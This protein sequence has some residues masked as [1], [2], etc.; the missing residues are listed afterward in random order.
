M[1]PGI[2]HSFWMCV[3]RWARGYQELQVP[4][5]RRCVTDS[6]TRYD[7]TT[8]DRCPEMNSLTTFSCKLEEYHHTAFSRRAK[9]AERWGST[10]WKDGNT[11]LSSAGQEQRCVGGIGIVV[12]RKWFSRN[13]SCCFALRNPC[14]SP[15]RRSQQNS[16]S[17]PSYASVTANSD[18]EVKSSVMN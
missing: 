3:L 10:T 7:S 15:S 16:Q 17:R 14:A 4:P 1:G 18:D 2:L 8:V 13:I 5:A 11:V 12:S 6:T 9:H